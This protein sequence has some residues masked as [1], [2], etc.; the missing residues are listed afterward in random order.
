MSNEM[1]NHGESTALLLMIERVCLDPNA[2]IE[3]LERM[4]AM[5][6]KIL[7][8]NAMQAFAADFSAMQISLPRISENGIGHNKAKYA[9]LEDINDAVRPVLHAHG[10]GISFSIDQSANSVTTR[11]KLSHRLGHLEETVLTLPIDTSGAKNPVQAAGSTISYGKRYALCALL[12]I[13]TGDDSDGNQAAAR[14]DFEAL[15]RPLADISAA[16]TLDELGAVWANVYK[17]FKSHPAY[18]QLESAKN[19]AKIILEKGV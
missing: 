9:L 5:Q 15:E 11:A 12:N 6:E 7:S 4:I 8:R 13:S 14:A 16:T 10:F 2:D 19:Q 18:K 1:I 3:K 17:S